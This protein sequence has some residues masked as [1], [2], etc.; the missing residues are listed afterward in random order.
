MPGPGPAQ[1]AITPVTPIV[2]LHVDQH[3]ICHAPHAQA[4]AWLSEY[5]YGDCAVLLHAPPTQSELHALQAGAAAAASAD[6]GA[7]GGA[8]GVSAAL[9]SALG[10]GAPGV[11]VE[12]G[13]G[14]AA[15]AY[16]GAGA[17]AGAA[18]AA[19]PVAAGPAG[20]SL[21]LKR[22]LARDLCPGAPH[23]LL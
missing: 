20:Y 15:S 22:V 11:A 23:I 12:G 3:G 2:V 18:A 1:G 16:S 19:R 17:A 13:A 7:A 14:G 21:V 9:A 4:R 6:A 10:Y 8:G 5:G